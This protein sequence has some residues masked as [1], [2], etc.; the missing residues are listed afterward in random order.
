MRYYLSILFLVLLFMVPWMADNY[1]EALNS[2]ASSIV[3]ASD[4]VAAVILSHNPKTIAQLRS[5]YS[6][7]IS[8]T[9]SPK[10]VR[11][12]IVPGHEPDFGG[13]EYGK[14]KEREMTVELAQDLRSFFQENDR[15]QVFTTRDTNGW[16]PT[17]SEYFKNGWN[18]I[19]AWQK[20][21]KDEI[22]KLK[23]LGKFKSV[24][25]SVIHNNAPDDVA[26]R[27]YGIDKWVNE[28][29]I[30]IVIHVH[31]NDYPRWNPGSPGKYSGFAI[32]VPEKQFF[33]GTTTHAVADTIFKRLQRYTPASNFPGENGGMVEDQD[34]IALG[35][36]NS[37][38]AASMLIEYGYIYEPQ[39]NDPAL[40]DAALKD[41][42][43]QTYLGVQDFFD[44]NGVTN[45]AGSYDTL[46]IPHQW[47]NGATADKPSSPDVFAL[48][49]AL[50]MNGVYPPSDKS[51]NDCPRSGSF[52]PCTKKAISDFQ[53]KYGITGEDG[54]IG[55]K[56]TEMLNRLYSARVI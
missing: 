44:P 46:L 43:F 37:V 53:K 24:S 30:D 54:N 2:I 18:D 1:P 4:Q 26:T 11:V 45:L 40:K 35:A 28:N 32:Y 9:V 51:M 49:T 50:S 5:D 3:G 25:P 34:L 19:I 55:V 29:N 27:L 20:I 31:F 23:A 13:A 10:K 17:F 39:F 16:N 7:P 48:Q 6:N 38:D 36:F 15:Y 56:T 14:I 33:N 41:L 21:H 8:P 12:L 22:I 52:G 42:A 47:G